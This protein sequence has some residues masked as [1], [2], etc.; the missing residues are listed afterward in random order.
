[1]KYKKR[2]LRLQARQKAWEQAKTGPGG[3]AHQKPGSKNK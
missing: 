3:H 2:L 1:M